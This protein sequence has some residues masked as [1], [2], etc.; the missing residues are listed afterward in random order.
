MDLTWWVVA[1][2]RL[3]RAGDC[4]W[5]RS[6]CGRWTRDASTPAPAGQRRPADPAARSTVRAARLRTLSAVIDD[7]AAGA[8]LRRCR[9]RRCPPD[10]I[11]YRGPAIRRCAAGGRHGVHRR[12]DRPIPPSAPSLRYFA[13]QVNAFGTQRI[14]LTSPNRRVVPLTRDYQYAAAQFGRYAAA[15]EQ[16]GCHC[17][18]R[19]CP[20]STTPPASR[21]SWRCA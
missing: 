21:T 17:G 6:C 7:R 8:G 10:R 15:S 9:A 4:A 14:G 18:R 1:I 2:A 11:A 16:R 13:D 19:R 12:A 5:R 3:R 20:T